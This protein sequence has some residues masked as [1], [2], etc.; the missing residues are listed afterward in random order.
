MA[1]EAIDSTGRKENGR[2]RSKQSNM[3]HTK[4]NSRIEKELT[5]QIFSIIQHNQTV[6]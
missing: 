5:K 1:E 4:D 2:L 3:V 6:K